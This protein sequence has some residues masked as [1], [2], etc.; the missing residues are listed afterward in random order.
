MRFLF[1]GVDEIVLG[2]HHCSTLEQ[3]AIFFRAALISK[4]GKVSNTDEFIYTWKYGK[5]L[6]NVTSETK[7]VWKWEWFENDLFFIS[8]YF[9]LFLTTKAAA[10]RTAVR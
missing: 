10:K 7:V 8:R 2:W 9:H 1:I 6:C 3:D 5:S 4:C